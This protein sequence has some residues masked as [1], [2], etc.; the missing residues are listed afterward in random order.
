[1]TDLRQL[2][3]EG[4]INDQASLRDRQSGIINAPIDT[5][6]DILTTIP[7][8]PTWNSSI[9]KIT[10]HNGLSS[11]SMFSWQ[12]QKIHINS[13]ISI[14][15]KPTTFGYISS[16]AGSKMIQ[17][18]NLEKSSETQTIVTCEVSMQGVRTLFYG[19][20]TLNYSLINWID[21]LRKK[22]ESNQS[23]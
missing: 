17:I 22:A 12:S 9:K 8:W 2:A 20:Q 18:W 3:K 23:T 14:V 4:K 13:E 11:G 6:W 1:M 7:D 19:H 10:T 15:S 5:V 16:I 21:K